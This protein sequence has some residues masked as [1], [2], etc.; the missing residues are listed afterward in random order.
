VT[1]TPEDTSPHVL[2]VD[3]DRRIRQLLSTYLAANGFRTT[4]AASAEAACVLMRSLTFDAIVLDIM[5]PGRSGLN[6]ASDLR[7]GNDGVP[8][9]FLSALAETE[10][11][12]VGLSA[13]GDD[14]L[15]KPFEPLELLLRLRSILRRSTTST[16]TTGEVR[17]GVCVFNPVR[18]ELRRGDEIVRLTTRERDIL[19]LFVQRHGQ[20]LSREMLRQGDREDGARAVDVQINR[21]RRKI[22]SDPANPVYLQT[23][24]GAGYTLHLD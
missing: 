9:L 21:L 12:I 8:I 22:E 17:F 13:G 4:V 14:Y 1:D 20:T 5:M 2:I 24:R 23:V 16:G 15:T 6:L 7:S 11:R 3:D 19:R 10:D 18:G